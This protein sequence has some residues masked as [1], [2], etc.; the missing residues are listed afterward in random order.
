MINRLFA[1]HAWLP[2]GWECDVLIEWDDTGSLQQVTPGQTPAPDDEVVQVVLP[3]MINLHSHSFQ[4]AMAGMTEK[5]G[6][7]QNGQN[8]QNGSSGPD[9]FWTWRDLMYRF[10]DF[11]TPEHLNAI[12]AQ[13]FVECLRHGYTSV[14]EFHYVQRQP[15]GAWYPRRAHM[16]EQIIGAAL[17][18][19]IGI[20]MLPV[21]YSY[22]NFGAV[23]LRPEQ[24]RFYTDVPQVLQLVQELELHRSPQVEIG[25]APHSLRAASIAQIAQ[26]LA[27]MPPERPV[28]MHIAEQV[29]EVNDCVA[30]SGRRPLAL[31]DEQLGLNHQWCLIH[32]THVSAAEI[33]SLARSGAVLGLCPSTEA[34]LGDGVFPLRDYLTQ[35]AALGVSARF[36]I[37]SDSHM[38]SSPVEELRWLEYGQRLTLQQRNVAAPAY[39]SRVA[40]YLWQQSA[41]AGAQACGRRVGSLAA[42]KR[43]DLI[44]LDE[45]HP[46]LF[47]L[48]HDDLLARFLF[49]GN[50]NLVRDVMTGGHWRVRGGR[51][52]EQETIALA[53]KQ[54]LCQL[55][56]LTRAHPSRAGK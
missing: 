55:R 38:G 27:A 42:G 21:L 29:Q 32:A 43:A 45:Q 11:I 35:C 23:P 26:L 50:D 3:G 17:H 14:C 20:T 12:A 47:D 10:V 28:H 2:Q 51:H 37:G 53:F 16:A 49:C 36:G 8:G 6:H 4:R 40:D 41:S 30:W 56:E 39:Q 44:V 13:L 33:H 19:G 48:D 31:L 7:G 46:T 34:N 54:T 25:V 22:A 52:I 1:H 5:T 18:S 15:D 24:K 9:S